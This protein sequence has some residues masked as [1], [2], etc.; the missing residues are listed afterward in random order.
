MLANPPVA[1]DVAMDDVDGARRA[2][3]SGRIVDQ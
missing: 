1:V 3:E 2:L